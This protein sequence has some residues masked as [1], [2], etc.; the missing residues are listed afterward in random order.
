MVTFVGK[1]KHDRKYLLA[2]NQIFTSKNILDPRSFLLHVRI[3]F[4][5]FD[6]LTKCSDRSGHLGTRNPV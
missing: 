5:Y 2:Y 6:F 3:G 1:T 4:V